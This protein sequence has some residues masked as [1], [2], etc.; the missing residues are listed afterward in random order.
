[1][2]GT[3]PTAYRSEPSYVDADV[4]T[5]AHFCLPDVPLIAGEL[6]TWEVT[7][8]SRPNQQVAVCTNTAYT[9]T[10]DLPVGAYDFRT[11]VS[12][13]IQTLDYYSQTSGK[14]DLTANIDNVLSNPSNQSYI[15]STTGNL[16][17]I[18]DALVASNG[19]WTF[20]SAHGLAVGDSFYVASASGDGRATTA[21][22]VEPN[23][24]GLLSV[25]SVV[26]TTRISSSVPVTI[27]D[28][29]AS[30]VQLQAVKTSDSTA[31]AI[32]NIYPESTGY[33]CVSAAEA[34]DASRSV[35]VLC[36]NDQAVIRGTAQQPIAAHGAI[37]GTV[38]TL[39]SGTAAYG[40]YVVALNE[41][42]AF[43][44]AGGLP[45]GYTAL[46]AA[47]VQQYLAALGAAGG[48]VSVGIVVG[49]RPSLR[50]RVS[51]FRWSGSPRPD[52]SLCRSH[53]P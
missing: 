1:M 33:L 24:M 39:T 28:Y 49:I 53:T 29:I 5:G 43:L 16:F 6:Y 3:K 48:L 36:P 11:F 19:V 46:T 30:G 26:D 51:R 35:C 22:F 50:C 23:V 38:L 41:Y 40:D 37:G 42:Y 9:G 12:P 17:C 14:F 44:E 52:G 21:P 7:L 13:G 31:T 45:S 27:S 2:L 18:Q 15:V 20:G 34:C 25:A 8:T 4:C 32:V 47:Q 10:S